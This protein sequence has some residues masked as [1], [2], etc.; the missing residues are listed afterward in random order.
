MPNDRWE[1]MQR[2][3]AQS[4]TDDQLRAECERRGFGGASYIEF[5]MMSADKD[6]AL[7]DR[8]EWKHSAL[9]LEG[10]LAKHLEWKRRAEAAEAESERR[11]LVVDAKNELLYGADAQR[12]QLAIDRFA[13][14]MTWYRDANNAPSSLPD[15]SA[16]GRKM[17]ESEPGI[18]TMRPDNSVAFLL[19]D[20]LADDAD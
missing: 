12:S 17:V 16:H 11:K 19:E 2:Q 9:E 4:L 6:R 1:D 7:R 15:T 8:D 20:L 13:G 10:E 5:N 3:L 18:A 14:R